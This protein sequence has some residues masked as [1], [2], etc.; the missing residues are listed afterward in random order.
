MRT[1]LLISALLFTGALAA[2]RVESRPEADQPS[3]EWVRTTRGWEPQAQLRS[4]PVDRTTAEPHPFV[5]A[6]FIGLSSVIVLLAF[7][8]RLELR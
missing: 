7:E 5:L 3:T 8:R 4:A 2:V 1:V 6:G